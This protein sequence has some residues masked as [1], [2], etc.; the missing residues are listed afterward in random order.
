MDRDNKLIMEALAN[1]LSKPASISHDISTKLFQAYYIVKDLIETL[2]KTPA[3]QTPYHEMALTHLVNLEESLKELDWMLKDR[4][5]KKSEN[6]EGRSA[7]QQA[8]IAISLQ[9]AGKKPS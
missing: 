7:A 5:L 8:A 2:D 1:S 3:E 4:M 9:K 6:A